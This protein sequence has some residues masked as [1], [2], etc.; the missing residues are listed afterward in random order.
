MSQAAV[1]AGL[2][3]PPSNRLNETPQFRTNFNGKRSK[4]YWGLIHA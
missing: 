3:L 2:R 4:G 1:M